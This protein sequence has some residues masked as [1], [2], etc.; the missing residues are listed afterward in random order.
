MLASMHRDF[1]D[2]V[3]EAI[4]RH[5]VVVV[6]MAQNP[7]VKRA[8]QALDAAGIAHHYIGHG[9]YLSGWRRR[10]ALKLWTG[11]PTFPMVFV[12]GTLIGG[13]SDLAAALADRSLQTT[14]N[15]AT[16]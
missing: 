15:N 2:E 16:G 4:E 14:L 1:I 6:G 10:L 12:R 13:A 7:F 8:R 9:S 3:R 5:P 11:S